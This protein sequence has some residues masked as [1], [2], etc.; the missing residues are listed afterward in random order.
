MATTATSSD[1]DYLDRYVAFLDILGFSDLTE[2]ADEHPDW[3]QYLRS[4]IDQLHNTLPRQVEQTGFRFVQFSDCIVMSADRSPDGLWAIFSGAK[5]LVTNMLHRGILLRGGIAAGRFFHDDRVMFGPALVR[6][7]TFDKPGAPPHIGIDPAIP[8]DLLDTAYNP[9][10]FSFISWD[11]WDLTPILHTLYDYEHYDPTP[12]SGKIVL[13]GP[14]KTVA[15]MLTRFA[16]DM[17][18][19]PGVRSKWRWMQDYWNR[20]VAVKGILATSAPLLQLPPSLP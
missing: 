17:R 2:K 14:A 5:M 1:A 11:P 4:I 20:T 15:E 6:A 3:R 16:G 8:S 12:V 10:F 19:P 18:T 7:H 9:G 13:D